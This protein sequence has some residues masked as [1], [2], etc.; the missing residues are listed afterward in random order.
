[1]LA[2]FGQAKAAR[3]GS[4]SSN[5]FYSGMPPNYTLFVCSHPYY[6]GFN[7]ECFRTNERAAFLGE[8][9]LIPL[10]GNSLGRSFLIKFSA[11][12]QSSGHT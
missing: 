8:N 12:R 3:I 2:A 5:N 10:F 9:N 6:S 1:M 4:V 7:W 11:H